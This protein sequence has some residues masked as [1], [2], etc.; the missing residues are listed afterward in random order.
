MRTERLWS[1]RPSERL[2]PIRA[3][4]GSL[5]RA[6]AV[7]VRAWPGGRAPLSIG[8]AVLVIGGWLVWQ[9]LLPVLVLDEYSDEYPDSALTNDLAALGRAFFHAEL[10]PEQGLGPL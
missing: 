1:C 7:R 8:T 6:P 9:V 10:S 4:M 2:E 5:V 3:R